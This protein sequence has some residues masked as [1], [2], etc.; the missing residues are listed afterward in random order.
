MDR[1]NFVR[2]GT[3]AGALALR[4]KS[5]PAMPVVAKDSSRVSRHSIADFELEEATIADLQSAMA[6]GRF[7]ARTIVEQYTDRIEELDR[8]GPELRQ[9]IEVNPDARSIAESLDAERKAGRL[10][11]QLHGI[12]V[13][14]KDNIDTA[15]R[16]T[17]TA[18][19]LALEGSIPARD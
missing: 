13:L 12:P 6:A 9:I 11:G 2:L 10:R 1:R 18:G 5:L 8:K 16:M 3:V 14:L 4:G 15:D 7:S 17:T 19:S